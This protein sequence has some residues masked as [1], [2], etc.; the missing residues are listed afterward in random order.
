MLHQG[1]GET[2]SKS[3]VVAITTHPF[4]AEFPNPLSLLWEQLV[5]GEKLHLQLIA[6]AI[7]YFQVQ[8]AT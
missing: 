2:L 1:V 8:L 7:T 5:S 6:P 4:N 3:Q